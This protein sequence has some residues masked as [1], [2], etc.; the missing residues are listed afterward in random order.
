[1]GITTGNRQ[2]ATG[3]GWN[4]D[5]SNYPLS[6]IRY[7]LI[8]TIGYWLLTIGSFSQEVTKSKKIET[9][10]NKKYYMHTVEK[11]QTLYAIAKEYSTTVND[12]ILENPDAI[13]GISPGQVLRIL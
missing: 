11:G 9:V 12:I 5:F 10:D 2:Q 13:D 8:I 7:S 4:E 3:N 1:M 6:A